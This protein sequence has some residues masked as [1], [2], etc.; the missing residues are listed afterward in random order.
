MREEQ[1]AKTAGRCVQRFHLRATCLN[2]ALAEKRERII[3]VVELER[4]T[5]RRKWASISLSL[6]TNNYA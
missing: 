5:C 1:K 4:K 3:S 2:A 6:S